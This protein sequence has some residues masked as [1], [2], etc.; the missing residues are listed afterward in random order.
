[1]K[2]KILKVLAFI[3]LAAMVIGAVSPGAFADETGASDDT[4]EFGDHKM[5]HG[6]RGGPVIYGET[7]EAPVFDTEDEEME[8]LVERI[9]ESINRKI[10]MLQ[11]MIENIDEIEDEDIT[12]DSIEEQI[13]ELEE[14]LKD[15]ESATTLDEL[16]EILEAGRESMMKEN[17]GKGERPEMEVME[18][19]SDEDEMQ[20]LVER[21]T[22]HITKRI[23]ML[24]EKLADTDNE[25][26]EA[27][28]E[29]QITELEELL[30]N[31]ESA[32]TLDG[33]KEILE[34]YSE[35]KPQQL[36]HGRECGPMGPAP[37]LE[38]GVSQVE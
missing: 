15:M 28:I 21:E 19:E 16:K 18:F 37:E 31:I 12:K 30:E 2:H 6:P 32:T 9:T 5:G 23:E 25:D 1:M 22:E 10:A 13:S 36:R 4:G 34:E 3:S 26:E 35:N 27:E 17:P 11:G 7:M 8:F 14:L 33:L 20:Y 38:E 24:N 29:E